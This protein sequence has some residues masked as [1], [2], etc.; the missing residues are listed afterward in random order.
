[1]FPLLGLTLREGICA[2]V[3]VAAIYRP[4]PPSSRSGWSVSFFYP[5]PKG[6]EVRCHTPHTYTTRRTQRVRQ[7]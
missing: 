5:R 1:M 3:S 2:C 7:S 4:P 6:K